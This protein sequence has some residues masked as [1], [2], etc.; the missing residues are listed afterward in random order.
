MNNALAI[1]LLDYYMMRFALAIRATEVAAF[2]ILT[3]GHE[4]RLS[5][6]RRIRGG[7]YESE[8]LQKAAEL[9]T[10]AVKKCVALNHEDAI[11]VEGPSST[12][13]SDYCVVALLRSDGPKSPP[14]GAVGAVVVCKG[15]DAARERLNCALR[16]IKNR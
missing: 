6:I 9:I 8:K 4:P 5:P 11:E 3:G 12:G 15:A 1:F 16:Y 7:D 14:I 10:E 13:Y 2:D